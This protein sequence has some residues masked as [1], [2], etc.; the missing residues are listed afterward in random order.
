MNDKDTILIVDDQETN[1]YTLRRYLERAGY[2]V[3]EAGSGEEGLQLAEQG[4]ALIILDVKLPDMIG[5]QVCRHLRSNPQTSSIPILQTSAAFV[6]SDDVIEGLE[7]GADGYLR[8]PIRPRELIATVNSLLR[9]R[10]AEQHADRLSHRWEACLDSLPQY[11]WI[12]NEQGEVTYANRRWRALA[13]RLGLDP[14]S[15]FFEAV[16]PEDRA[17][18][19][20]DWETAIEQKVDFAQ[21]YRL[22]D[23][24][25]EYRWQLTRVIPLRSPNDPSDYWVASSTDI[26]SQKQAQVATVKAKEE[27]EAAS[28]AKSNF[29]SNMSHE[30][31][32]PLTS[33]IG[34]AEILKE[35]ADRE[36][37]DMAEL[38]HSNSQ[39]LLGTINSV[40]DLARLESGKTKLSIS[41]H[42]I[43]REVNETV[44][45]MQLQARDAGNE[46]AVT[47]CDVPVRILADQAA[48]HR[49]LTN[50]IGNSVK[51]TQNGK[52]EVR[53]EEAEQ[54]AR[55]IISD[56]GRGIS[57]DFRTRLFRPFEQESSG[58]NRRH[59][60]SGLGLAITHQLVQL[61]NGR[62][63]VQS[64][65]DKG[66]TFIVSLPLA[67]RNAEENAQSE[68][69][70]TRHSMPPKS[71][72]KKGPVLVVEDNAH[73]VKVMRLLLQDRYEIDF[74]LTAEEALEHAQQRHY[75]LVFLDINLGET[76]GI[77][78]LEQLRAIEGYDQTVMVAF[79]AFSLPGDRERFESMGFDTYLGKPF[80]AEQLVN[81]IE[82]SLEG[83]AS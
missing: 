19:K 69:Q 10:R 24:D 20:R 23:P 32:T 1:R 64:E 81:L 11:V 36:L 57:P 54:S 41:P 40:L 77:N 22:R 74:A 52:I 13:K 27:A 48:L 56:T 59:E 70:T 37:Q 9:M 83:R 14:H 65:P 8:D 50:L 55:F 67:E 60:G 53:V 7:S 25:N 76:T 49:I 62:I 78:A 66:T 79:T 80:R 35:K 26:D 58:E 18:L 73:T 30:I 38:L 47:G 6:D 63:E 71:A 17:A 15:G 44:D 29:L 16:Y 68:P 2:E 51:F 46:I 42:D 72:V 34:M 43:C 3:Q 82:K 75:K 61:M 39:R 31:R 12:M 33:I 45:L 5:Y 21:E 4:P 28:R